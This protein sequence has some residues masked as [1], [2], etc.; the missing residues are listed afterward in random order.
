M[1]A[2]TIQFE[3]AQTT[4]F[5]P[6]VTGNVVSMAKGMDGRME[7]ETEDLHPNS[8]TEEGMKTFCSLMNNGMLLQASNTCGFQRVRELR[9]KTV[10]DLLTKH[11]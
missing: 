2:I 11:M 10:M 5:K 4:G 7:G 3:T 9:T 1:N 8:M 6:D